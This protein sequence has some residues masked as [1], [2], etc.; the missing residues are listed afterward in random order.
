MAAP[1]AIERGPFSYDSY[2]LTSTTAND[3]PADRKFDLTTGTQFDPDIN[4]TIEVLVNG[5][6]LK[7][8]G[9]TATTGGG[10]EFFVDSITAPTRVT[11]VPDGTLLSLNAASD[12]STVESLAVSD[13]LVIRRISNRT[14]K[15]VDY[16]PGSVIREVD[17]DSSNTQIIHVAQEA[18][19]IAISG[20]ILETN[21]KFDGRSK[22]VENLEDGVADNDAV[23]KGQLD[24]TEVTT[25]G[26]KED[27]EDY[28]LETADWATKVNAVVNT[29]TDNVAQADGTEYSAKEYALGTTV[30]AGSAKDWAVLPEDSVVT[31]SSYSALHH[32]TKAASS[33][34]AANASADA[35]AVMYDAFH[36]KFL[37]SMVDTAAQGTNPT[38]IVCS[39]SKNSSTITVAS[40][41]NMKI[42][43][44]VVGTGIETSPVPNIISIH[45]SA[46]TIVISDN[47][48]AAGSS[49][50]LTFTGHGVYG[51]FHVAKDGPELNNDGDAL[52]D[53]L[54]YFNAT[55]DVLKVYDV[56]ST[57]WKQ[58][59]PT[60]T[61]QA[62][63]DAVNAD[64]IDIGKVAAI[65]TEIGQLAVL[66]SGGVDI[67][68]VSNIGTD[69]A[70]VSTVADLDT[71][72]G[73]LGALDT[74]IG[75]LGTAGMA[76]ATTGNL[77]KLGAGYDGT[78]TQTGTTTNLAQI[79]A[80]AL[81]IANV[82][83]F[84]NR[85][86]IA[87]N[88]DLPL[89][90]LD[91]GDLYWNTDEDELFIY[92][93]TSGSWQSTAP[94]LSN[95][96]NIDIVAGNLIYQEDLGLITSAVTT[97]S[98]SSISNVAAMEAEIV[99]LG[100][101]AMSTASTGSLA[102]LGTEAM[103]HATTG[104]IKKVADIDSDVTAVA[105]D[106]V[107]IGLV[108]AVA[109][110]IELLGTSGNVTNMG[111][112]TATGV[113]ADI[114]TVADIDDKVTSVANIATEIEQVVGELVYQEDL[115]SIADAA[116]TTTGNNIT[117]VAGVITEIGLLGTNNMAHP[118]TGH[119]AYLGTPVMTNTSNGYL[120]VL[121]N[122]TV[123]DDMAILGSTTVTDDM[124][125]L[126]NTTITDDMALL[127]A[128]GVIDDT[129]ICSNNISDINNFADQY[130]IASTT[131]GSPSAG[132]LWY[133]STSNVLKYYTGSGFSVIAA[134]I[135]NVEDDSSP[136]LG[137][138]L[139]ADSKNITNMGSIDGANL[140]INFGTIA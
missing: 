9:G 83:N 97:S 20:M 125:L 46:D 112:L 69:G 85:Y 96:A 44:I 37:G 114:D 31:G 122:T 133:D 109:T 6:K 77:A 74:E 28:K 91:A 71:E 132:D 67:T 59:T 90:S 94:S 124:A 82:N 33:E 43:Q 5:V 75:L 23:N 106:A 42:G 22:V 95:Q 57:S 34:V 117:D 38:N 135:L 116:T 111:T 49:V 138:N 66:G 137:G 120:K 134:G 16:A 118:T 51:T 27:T 68:T 89:P 35:V 110:E 86:R 78:A 105:L 18:M 13:K 45:P 92:N 139:D 99:R 88:A 126:A 70:D 80:V 119:L 4:E 107:D 81:G 93:G 47:M 24:A 136:T 17:L 10:D 36:D 14:S 41:T 55:D 130:T 65:D 108:A 84:A 30:A 32:A 129:E 100:T 15:N 87:A 39:W 2:T 113:I 98:G 58:T 73:L 25:L 12:G 1:A 3:D 63:I 52:T 7:G 79:N 76:H 115:G 54:L 128:A 11:I 19:D 8:S 21:D 60:T 104:N 26:Y 50:E 102:L 121:G 64:A 140:N 56:T 101:T 29:Y 53:G 40:K 131:P 62:A 48:D 123:T 72:V 103:A 127:G 61:Q